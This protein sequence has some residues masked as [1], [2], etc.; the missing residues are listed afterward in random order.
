MFLAARSTAEEMDLEQ[1][2]H[3]EQRSSSG[4]NRKVAEG[5]TDTSVFT[6]DV[7][8]AAAALAVESAPVVLAQAVRA[9]ARQLLAALVD[10]WNGREESARKVQA[11]RWRKLSKAKY[12]GNGNRRP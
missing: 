10:V 11:Q 1:Q 5:L 3:E 7:H 2:R 8:Q 12:L 4:K 6:P 9:G